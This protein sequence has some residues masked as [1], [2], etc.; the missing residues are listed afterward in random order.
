MED[1]S[2]F[3]SKGARLIK[4][5]ELGPE[6][7]DLV[8]THIGEQ[9]LLQFQRVAD[10]LVKERLPVHIAVPY[11]HYILERGV[12][13]KKN[14]WEFD[15]VLLRNTFNEG[16]R[17]LEA[18]MVS[19]S[20]PNQHKNIINSLLIRIPLPLFVVEERINVRG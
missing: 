14:S 3:L 15:R 19:P 4:G 1:H 10:L 9:Y 17:N 12:E 2:Q 8:N 11:C 18:L 6:V 13:D 20:T 7:E 5:L 16:A